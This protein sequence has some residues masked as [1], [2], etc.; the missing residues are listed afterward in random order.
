MQGSAVRK[1]KS[2]RGRGLMTART[3]GNVFHSGDKKKE[4]EPQ[5]GAKGVPLNRQLQLIEAPWPFDASLRVRRDSRLAGLH[6]APR[7]WQLSGKLQAPLVLVP[8]R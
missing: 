6:S 1:S 3:P 2:N 7:P 4:H 8:F 5:K